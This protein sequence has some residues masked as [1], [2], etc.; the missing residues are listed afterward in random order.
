[1]ANRR[2]L[3]QIV[4]DISLPDSSPFAKL[5]D[6]CIHSKSLH[7][8]HRLHARIIKSPFAS[9]TFILNRLID[10]FENCKQLEQALKKSTE[11]KK[12]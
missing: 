1:M 12:I 7:G 8:V 4:G 5:L 3:K 11:N 9:E 6:S 2:L 10:A